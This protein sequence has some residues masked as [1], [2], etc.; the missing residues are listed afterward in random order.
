M[1]F[2]SQAEH[3]SPAADVKRDG[4]TAVGHGLSLHGGSDHTSMPQR[5]ITQPKARE[6][7]PAVH[8]IVSDRGEPPASAHK[9]LAAAAA[10]TTVE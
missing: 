8:S 10:A 6:H 9:L 3:S 7:C 4:S 1:H 5:S 2:K